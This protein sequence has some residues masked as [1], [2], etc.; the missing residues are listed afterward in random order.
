MNTEKGFVVLC[1][2]CFRPM[3][4]I[5]DLWFEC[6]QDEDACDGMLLPEDVC[7]QMDAVEATANWWRRAVGGR[8]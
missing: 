8:E 7:V 5:A 3:K 4:H 1:P 6:S 2:V